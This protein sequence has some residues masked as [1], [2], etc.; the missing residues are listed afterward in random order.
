MRYQFRK[1]K[2]AKVQETDLSLFE[3]IH[4]GKIRPDEVTKDTEQIYQA[5][6]VLED[7]EWFLE[8]NSLIT[9]H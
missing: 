8:I 4:Q 7:F 9:W 1:L 6:E 3:A 5:M 2:D